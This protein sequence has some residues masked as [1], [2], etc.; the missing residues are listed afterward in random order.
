M[1]KTFYSR[2]LLLLLSIGLTVQ[3]SHAERGRGTR[4]LAAREIQEQGFSPYRKKIALLVGINDY[5]NGIPPLRYAVRDAQAIA[6]LLRNHLEFDTVYVLKNDEATRSAILHRII[7]LQD[8]TSDEDQLFVYFAGHGVSFGEGEAEIG[9]LLAQDAKGTDQ[10]AAT[11]GGIS[12]ND[13]MDHLLQLPPKHLLVA[14]DACHGGFAARGW[15]SRRGLP[16]GILTWSKARQ[17]ITAG[18][19]Y[20]DSLESSRWEGHSAFTFKLLQGLSEGRADHN[21]DGFVPTTELYSFLQSEV[22]TLT[23]GEQTPQYARLRNDEGEF[24]FVLPEALPSKPLPGAAE[25][26]GS[27]P[28]RDGLGLQSK[29]IV[30]RPDAELYAGPRGS[31]S[32]R[33][34]Y[35]DVF[36]ALDGEEGSLVPVAR[37]PNL[38]RHDG[39]LEAGTFAAWETDRLL[40]IDLEPE[41]REL[42]VFADARCARKF[43]LGETVESCKP[44]NAVSRQMLGRRLFPL[45]EANGDVYR[46]G[47]PALA[48]KARDGRWHRAKGYSRLEYDLIMVVDTTS[49]MESYFHSIAH[50]LEVFMEQIK[51]DER[52][53][54]IPIHLSLLFFRDHSDRSTCDLEYL[55][56]WQTTPSEGIGAALRA[57]RSASAARCDDGDS[58]EAVYDGLKQ[59]IVEGDWH[60][61]AF[62]TIWLIGDEPPHPPSR[63][64]KNP[65]ELTVQEIHNLAEERNVRLLTFKIDPYDFDQYES[66]ALEASDGLMGR[67]RLLSPKPAALQQELLDT[68]RE[69]WRQVL[70]TQE[71]IDTESPESMAGEAVFFEGWLPRRVQGKPIINEYAVVTK[72]EAAALAGVIESIAIAAEG[73]S[74]E[75]SEAFLD[76][77]GG[78]LSQILKDVEKGDVFKLGNHLETWLIQEADLL[79]FEEELLD[80]TAEDV[81]N[82]DPE[83][84][85]M[86]SERLGKR[87]ENLRDQLSDPTNTYFLGDRRHV[88]MPQQLRR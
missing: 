86:L 73:A 25:Q 71:S 1:R 88:F 34:D 13:L 74:W 64:D 85:R 29:A 10:S 23:Q 2:G 72:S 56:R 12:M 81:R 59:A 61:G 6:D 78:V 32:T 45:L 84:F 16:P 60:A 14:I 51:Q 67:F 43:G 40:A 58:A 65:L 39:W 37:E 27:S 82:W 66:L 8:E 44:V 26:D 22:A 49:G 83:Y 55:T 54:T 41:R 30:T 9:Y 48:V 11:D 70:E 47:F 63:Q 46:V 20:E 87:A 38:S 5:R 52:A 76:E 15:Q 21:R 69:E 75:G 62:K 19:R 53:E 68:L 28:K 79:S 57:L 33:V 80:F 18:S 50:S 17:I 3:S 36:F 24:I 31:S 4:T 7:Q 77:L 35:L 42:P